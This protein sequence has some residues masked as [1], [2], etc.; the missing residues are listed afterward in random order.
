MRTSTL[1][2]RVAPSRCTSWSCSTRSSFACTSPRQVADLVEEEG[3][4]V[5]ELEAAGTGADGAGERPL[6]VPEQ[7]A[8]EQ[9]GGDR[10]AVDLDQTVPWLSGSERGSRWRTAP[11]RSRSRRAAARCC[12]TAPPAPSGRPPA[13]APPSRPR[14]RPGAGPRRARPAGS[15]PRPRRAPSTPALPLGC[16]GAPP[17]SSCGAGRWPGSGRRFAGAARPVGSTRGSGARSRSRG[18][19]RNARRQPPARPGAT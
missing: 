19:R 6:L 15:R 1:R 3:A 7:L 16:A 8:L 9:G 11:C 10:G 2:E 12:P 5:G 18:R 13:A 4:A 17:R 14:S